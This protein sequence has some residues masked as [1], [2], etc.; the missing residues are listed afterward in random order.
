M[1]SETNPIGLYN[2]K[3]YIVTR[4]TDQE[5]TIGDCQHLQQ[6]PGRVSHGLVSSEYE[7]ADRVE[8]KT[9]NSQWQYDV[10]NGCKC[11][12]FKR[13]QRATV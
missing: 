8:D 7:R 3:L 13:P 10:D 11:H 1:V 2:D 12:R 9:D 4:V 6:K 5:Y